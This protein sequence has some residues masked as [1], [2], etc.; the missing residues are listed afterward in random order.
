MFCF[1][2]FVFVFFFQDE[3]RGCSVCQFR[4]KIV[5]FRLTASPSLGL[6]RDDECEQSSEGDLKLSRLFIMAVRQGCN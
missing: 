4:Q 3:F 1:A 6:P 2:F 5:F